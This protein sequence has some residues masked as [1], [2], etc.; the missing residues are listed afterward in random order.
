MMSDH[1]L[2]Q[3]ALKTVASNLKQFLDQKR[4]PND[5]VNAITLTSYD[6]DKW[7]AIKEQ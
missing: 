5:E 7:D 6:V 4:I 2:P 3:S 1:C